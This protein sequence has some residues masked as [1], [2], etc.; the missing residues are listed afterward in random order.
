MTWWGYKAAGTAIVAGARLGS[1]LGGNA[2]AV[3]STRF[4]GRGARRGYLAPG[5]PAPPPSAVTD[6]LDYRGAASW[7]EAR[8]LLGAPFSLG[9]FAD[10]RRG[11]YRGPIGLPEQVLNRHAV[12]VG[13][14]GSGKT[15]SL[16]LP[17][18]LAALAADWS[19]VAI[20]IKG[21]LREDFLAH[22]QR[23][24]PGPLGARIGSWDF[25]SPSTSLAWEWLGELVDEARVDA[26]VTAII[27]RKP[28]H[29]TADP[30]FYD[31]DYRTLR[32]LLTFACS[33]LPHIRTAGELI[34]LLED[35]VALDAM[36]KQNPRA[37]GAAD[38]TPA[39]S[40]PAAEYPKIISGV[41]TALSTINT[42]AANSVMRADRGLSALRLDDALDAHSLLIIGA[43]LRGG[44]LATTLSSLLLNQL[45]QRFYERFG[46]ERRPVL[47]VVDEAPQVASRVDIAQLMEVARSAGVGVVVAMQDVARIREDTER[48]SILSNAAV[49][50]ILPGASPISIE[51]FGKRL[52]TRHERTVGMTV[53]G[54]HTGWGAGPPSRSYGLETVPVLRERE[55]MQPPFAGRPAVVHVKAGDIGVTG[56]PLLVNMHRE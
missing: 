19:V 33:A 47:L 26:A 35:D 34:A 13:P 52:G 40:F 9:A 25:M 23:H 51:E 37:P 3:G 50:A 15:H 4:A 2:A 41:V 12:V 10:L 1:R 22:K 7:P 17:W 20:D 14:S 55:I 46:A 6:Y 39:L 45:T 16:V 8:N 36:L 11:R 28:E 49:F 21:D 5:D 24:A 53:G 31:R 38:L 43:A 30:Y 29:S 27:G 44:Q 32:G 18:M 54:P 56:K 42:P 48:S